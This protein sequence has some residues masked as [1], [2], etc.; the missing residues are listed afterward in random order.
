VTQ[1]PNSGLCRFIVKISRS[2]T[3]R[4]THT[5]GRTPLDEWSARRRDL[6][7]W[8]HTDT[9]KRHTS[10]PPMGFFSRPV[11]SSDPF[12]TFESVPPS[13]CDFC[14]ILL[15]LYNKHNTNIHAPGGIRTHNPSKRAAADPRLRPR[16]HWDRPSLLL[17]RTLLGAALFNS[18]EKGRGG[19]MGKN[20]AFGALP[21]D[22][23]SGNSPLLA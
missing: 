11:C 13:S 20:K 23:Y 19:G 7:L 14:S 17:A 10:M 5:A 15:S 8:Q 12:C 22:L 6:Y 1:E 16:G 21:D 2:H 9:H 18:L 4:H 3:I